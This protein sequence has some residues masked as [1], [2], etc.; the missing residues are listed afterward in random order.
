MNSKTR[1][2]LISLMTAGL[3]AS[4]L[5]GLCDA[6]SP[7]GKF[8]PN[9]SDGANFIGQ[10][11]LDE[12]IAQAVRLHAKGYEEAVDV[13]LQ[14]AKNGTY[15]HQYADALI[16]FCG[17]IWTPQMSEKVT[18]KTDKLIQEA[19]TIIEKMPEYE[20]NRFHSLLKLEKYYRRTGNTGKADQ[21]ATQMDNLVTDALKQDSLPVAAAQGCLRLLE[22]RA[23]DGDFKA[24]KGY[25]SQLNAE[26]YEKTAHY[27]DQMEL[28]LNK[29]PNNKNMQAEYLREA[30][31]F[32]WTNNKIEL[33][34]AT[35]E[36]LSKLLGSTD[37]KV[38]FPKPVRC[39]ACGMG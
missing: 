10:V 3:S 4:T 13:N 2:L 9:S 27:I 11:A 16:S 12:L 36:K 14:K 18:A 33:M 22:I 39:P 34:S 20:S 37:E 17:A 1:A 21:I 28:L 6:S 25:A 35:K 30:Y 19:I 24:K 8:D 15:E 31:F 26:T 23:K 7:D 29:I 32:Y 5:P 38:L